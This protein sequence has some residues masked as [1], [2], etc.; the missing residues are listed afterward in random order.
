MKKNL[1]FW[2]FTDSAETWNGRLAMIG[3][4]TVV[5]I[6]LVTSKG[7]LYLAGLMD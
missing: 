3:F 6:E 7:L 4:I 2:G 5:F 1:W